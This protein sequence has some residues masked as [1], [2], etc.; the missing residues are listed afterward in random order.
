MINQTK[1]KTRMLGPMKEEEEVKMKGECVVRC[2]VKNKEIQ[3]V[4]LKNVMFVKNTRKN[5][6]S[7]KKLCEG[8]AK[9]KFK[10]EKFEVTIKGRMIIENELSLVNKRFDLKNIEK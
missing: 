8:G 6:I 5:L 1:T 3:Q 7:V 10:G 9:V 4:R 2:K